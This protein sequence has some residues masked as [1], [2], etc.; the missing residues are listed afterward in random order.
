MKLWLCRHA[1]VQLD[2]GICYGKT[3]VQADPAGT[4][5][6]ADQLAQVLPQGCPV[7]ASPLARTRQLADALT[8]LRP[9]LGPV[10]WDASLQEMDFGHWEMQTWDSIGQP[11]VDD[12]VDNFAHHSVGGAES[13]LDVV[14]RVALMLVKSQALNL[15]DVIWI[16]HAGVIRAVQYLL[17][18]PHTQ[19][20][21]C[22]TWPVNAPK[23][24]AYCCIDIAGFNGLKT[25]PT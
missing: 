3:D 5:L 14:K 25:S 4:R 20:L 17:Q 24:G 2:A 1:P 10:V 6:A 16:T 11:A 18:A 12:W 21:S 9:D 7:W 15:P 19:A 13:T 23:P 8:D 22:D